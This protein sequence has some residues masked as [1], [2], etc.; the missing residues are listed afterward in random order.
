[1]LAKKV[2][3]KNGIYRYE[4]NLSSYINNYD[5]KLVNISENYIQPKHIVRYKIISKETYSDEDKVNP[6]MVNYFLLIE[7]TT[8][9]KLK[10]EIAEMDATE[11][12]LNR[13]NYKEE[14]ERV[15]NSMFELMM[16]IE[17]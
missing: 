6:I 10:F 15:E 4:T 5:F 8:G 12:E 13:D 7:L 14:L 16:G 2:K 3:D 9:T 17:D 11:D 1:M